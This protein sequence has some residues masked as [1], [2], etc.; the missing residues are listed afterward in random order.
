MKK[1]TE[2]LKQTKK[3]NLKYIEQ[4][5]LT[6]D[7][8]EILLKYNL[9]IHELCYR[10]K[11]NIA[12]DEKFLCKQCGTKIIFDRKH[13]Y[14]DFCN[15]KCS[16]KYSA[17]GESARKRVATNIERYG[18]SCTLH[19][20]DIHQKALETW[21]Q[22]YNT[23][24]PNKSNIVKD[25]KKQAY[26]KKF[27]VDNYSKTKEYKEKVKQTNIEKFGKES[28]TQTDEYK[29]RV[30]Q[31]C[32]EK[33]GV[34]H[35]TKSK[36]YRDRLKDFKE[37]YKQTCLEKY[38]TEY[39]EQSD[40]YKKKFD[41]ILAKRK[42][43]F[44]KKYGVESYSESA[45]YKARLSEIQEKRYQTQKRNQTFN[46]S[47]PEKLAH[48]MLQQKFSK[49]MSQYKSALYPFK[50][51]FYIPEKD[52]YV[53]CHFGF[54]HNGKPFDKNNIEHLKELEDIKSKVTKFSRNN[55]YKQLIYTWTDLDVRKLETFKKNKLNYKIFYTL[56]EF[57]D[58]LTSQI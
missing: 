56:D 58:W 47:K 37:K 34:D 53:E 32:L 43:T 29:D 13:Y 42:E 25:K 48:E 39:Y 22:K 19:N 14:K 52:L 5:F 50:C 10:L 15:K 28:Y 11:N 49:V 51:D 20:K 41:K 16:G 36:E 8:K 9:T 1:L 24:S 6:N 30:K 27:G 3:Y 21:K 23:D 44:K 46:S 38:G 40:V 7:V 45:E 2:F 33:Y 18:T 12:L 54:F 57:K 17:Q 31:I 35:Y 4:N 26:L 55:K